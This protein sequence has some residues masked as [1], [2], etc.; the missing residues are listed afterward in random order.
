MIF[1]AAALIVK[2][3]H[4]LAHAGDFDAQADAVQRPRARAQ[5]LRRRNVAALNQRAAHGV[6]DRLNAGQAS[7]PR[8]RPAEPRP[9]RLRSVF[10]LKRSRWPEPS[11][12]GR[13]WRLETR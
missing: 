6:A 9:A 8:R 4:L 2:G 3:E 13:A 1:S 11:R 5:Q 10:L 7:R 12:Q